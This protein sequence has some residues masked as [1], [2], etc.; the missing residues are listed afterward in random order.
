MP[1]YNSDVASIFSRI[2][3]L[4]EIE[5]ANTY[6]V[7]AYRNAA[8]TVAT[9]SGNIADMVE[10][11]EDLTELEGI[12][13][14][15]AGK[16]EEMAKTGDLEQLE[17]I[18]QRVPP[19]LAE[20]LDISGLGPKRV[21][22]LYDE[23][24]ITN[25]EELEEAAKQRKI[26]KLEGFGAKIQQKILDDLEEAR[27]KEKRTRLDTADELVVPLLD[28]LRGI[29][30]VQ[31]VEAAGSYRRRQETVGDLDVLVTGEEGQ[32]IIDRFIEYEDVDE[33]VS[34]GKTRSTVLL[35]TG[36]R[37]DLRVVVEESYGAALLYFTGSKAHNIHLRNMALHQDMKINEYGVFRGEERIAGETEEE[38]YG[39]FDMP[40]I[41][42]ELRED[43][44]EIDAAM[45]GRLPQLVTLD[46][47]RGDLQMHT[48]ASDGHNTLEEM[49]E[50][51]QE[52]GYDY[53]A[54]TDHSPRVAVAQGLDAEH[55][56][57][58]IDEIDELNEKL[59]GIRVL[60]GIEVD[61]LEDGSLDLPDDVLSRLDVVVASVHSGF[62]FSRDKQT[63]RILRAM[64]NPNFHILAH[65]TGRLIN[66]RDPYEVDLEKVM[67]GALDRGCYL[68]VNALPNRL[69]LD[70]VHARMAKEMG[71]KLSISTDAH[72]VSELAYM[73][74]GVGQARRGWLEPDDVLNTR[75][76]R[77]LHK[78]L[79]R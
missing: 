30:G 16:I 49:V 51:A 29:E 76:W 57:K 15:L 41:E 61:I 26:E 23:L 75:S 73:R 3:D 42:P 21:R 9:L 13:E 77:D 53:V 74:F 58:R 2:A 5:G 6:R 43:R 69:D 70:D 33:V 24:G 25:L 44:G 66:E 32:Q 50:A 71:L 19:G 46:D 63:E 48:T 68:E 12:G 52:R 64:D 38:I 59:G 78:L 34:E 31:R 17:E 45:E 18:E 60:K 28:Y 11:G 1:V 10:N 79:K 72:R 40:Y 14:D 54:I 65:P 67:Q 7:R 22:A 47:V 35:R 39:L 8:R 27:G 37:V 4:L 20:L 36:L 62:G 56:A 55:L